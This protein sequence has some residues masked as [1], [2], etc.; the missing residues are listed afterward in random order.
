MALDLARCSA[1]IYVIFHHIAQTHEITG[2]IRLIFSFG[3]EA[4]LVFFVLSGFVIFANEHGRAIPPQNYYMRRIRRI[5][6]TLIIAC[7]IGAV[8]ALDNGNLAA[9]MDWRRLFGTLAGLQD[10]SAL[11]PGVIVDPY[12]GNTPLWSLSYE[13][14]FYL[15]F[16]LALMLWHRMPRSSNYII[17]VISFASFAFYILIPNHLSLVTA[18]F[19][20]WWCGAMA[21]NAYLSGAR[22]ALALTTPLLWLSALTGLAVLNVT[23]QGFSSFGTYPFLMVRHFVVAIFLIIFFFGPLGVCAARIS[24]PA[25][26]PI[27]FLASISYGLYAFHYPILIRWDRADSAIGTVLAVIFLIAFAI[28]GDRWTQKY[29][30]RFI[31][32]A[33][34][35]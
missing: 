28:A 8:V 34:R 6:P 10:V 23:W 27:I 19:L 32:T 22:N 16:P 24:W 13:M 7:L 35:S 9:I 26:K 1:A 30:P 3:Q 17:G 4:V 31:G 33:S 12:A 15:I 11:K 21:A 29:L 20:V 14:F 2:L 5:Y 18:Y 25:A